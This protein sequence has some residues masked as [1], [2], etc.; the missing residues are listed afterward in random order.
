MLHKYVCV[1]FVAIFREKKSCL[2]SLKNRKNW[3]DYKFSS[4]IESKTRLDKDIIQLNKN[5]GPR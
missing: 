1:H 3:T 2:I 5:V 4:I